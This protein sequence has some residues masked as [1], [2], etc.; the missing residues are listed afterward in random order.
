MIQTT[1]D[2]M[3]PNIADVLNIGKFGFRICF[4]FRSSYLE[5]FGQA[6]AQ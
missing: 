1:P 3:I 4:V 6:K 5:F 2:G